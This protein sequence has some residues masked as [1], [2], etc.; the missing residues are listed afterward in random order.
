MKSRSILNVVL[1]CV[2]L[3]L[4]AV[5]AFSS[6]EQDEVVSLMDLRAGAIN[7]ITVNLP[8]KESVLL[9]RKASGWEIVEPIEAQANSFRIE[10][11]L[12]LAEARSYAS[13]S[14]RPQDLKRYQLAPPLGSIKFNDQHFSFGAVEPLNRRRYV[15]NNDTVQLIAERYYYQAMVA[16]PALLDPAILP[17][18]SDLKKIELPGF[19]V[20]RDADSGWKIDGSELLSMEDVNALVQKWQQ[21]KATQI[22]AYNDDASEA[23]IKIQ[24][25][26]GRLFEFDLLQTDPEL[27]LGR[28]DMGMRYHLGEQSGLLGFSRKLEN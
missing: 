20:I 15:L 22:T 6:N 3:A 24:L 13:Y 18:E 11:L 5:V 4:L 1:L 9:V 7:E 26:D 2:V 17:S 19:S 12:Q 28:R 25:S 8:Y 23:V 14:V 21:A 27:I 10:M 16:L